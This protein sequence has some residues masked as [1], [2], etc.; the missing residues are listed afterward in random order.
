[1]G[2]SSLCCRSWKAS[3]DEI[4]VIKFGIG[5]IGI[6]RLYQVWRENTL[7]KATRL[8]S[9]FLSSPSD[10][11]VASRRFSKEMRSSRLFN[12]E[13][14][15]TLLKTKGNL[16]VFPTEEH[17]HLKSGYLQI[18][19]SSPMRENLSSARQKLNRGHKL[20]GESDGAIGH[21]VVPLQLP[22]TVLRLVE[23]LHLRVVKRTTV[24]QSVSLEQQYDCRSH[25]R[26]KVFKLSWQSDWD[27]F[28]GSS[29]GSNVED[30][31]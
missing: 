21:V 4:R 1:M 12:R 19:L 23:L 10:N 8:H 28:T 30:F 20:V 14:L 5:R 9:V 27:S 17:R 6:E 13:V 31:Y 7:G 3:K 2:V 24:G 11:S 26:N 18:I 29:P 22:A 25:L 15:T 16:P